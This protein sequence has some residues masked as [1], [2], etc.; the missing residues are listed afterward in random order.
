MK[1]A[2]EAPSVQRGDQ[3]FRGQSKGQHFQK[4]IRQGHIGHNVSGPTY[5]HAKRD[6][7]GGL[8]PLGKPAGSVNG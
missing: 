7:N 4:G 8:G 6:A 5:G 1:R 3:D 2:R